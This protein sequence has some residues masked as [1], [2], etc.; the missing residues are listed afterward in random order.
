M[1]LVAETIGKA[2]CVAGS[3]AIFYASIKIAFGG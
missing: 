2:I 3:M 1:I